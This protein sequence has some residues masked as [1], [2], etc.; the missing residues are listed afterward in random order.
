MNQEGEFI[1]LGGPGSVGPVGAEGR[2]PRG[3]VGARVVRQNT[4]WPS[5]I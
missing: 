1:S 5:S 4:G 2:S 3:W